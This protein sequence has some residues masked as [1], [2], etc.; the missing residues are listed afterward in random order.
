MIS[1]G[2]RLAMIT[3]LPSG[4]AHDAPERRALLENWDKP[5]EIVQLEM[6]RAYEGDK[7]RQRVRDLGM[8]PFVPPKGNR[9]KPWDYDRN[10]YKLRNEV[11]RLFGRLKRWRRGFT[12]HDKLDVM[13]LAFVG[14]VLIF[15]M[16]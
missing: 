10:I 6:D 9:K 15:D 16:N 12:R 8:I 2:D 1:T 3:G 13:Q 7:T 5:V 4:Q 11:E 14:L